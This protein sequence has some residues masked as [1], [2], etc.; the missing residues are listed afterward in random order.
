MICDDPPTHERVIQIYQHQNASQDSN[1]IKNRK[2]YVLLDRLRSGH[3]PSLHYYLHRLDPAQDP[4]CPS[5]C[6]DEQDP[7]HWL[8]ESPAGDVIRQQVFGNHKESLERLATRPE[9]VVKLPHLNNF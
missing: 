5:C 2:D 1:Q 3:H 7:N 8:C 9:D 6:F 4:I